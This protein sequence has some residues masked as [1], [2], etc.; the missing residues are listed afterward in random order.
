MRIITNSPYNAHAL[1]LF[2]KLNQLT[3]YDLNKLSVVTFMYR[4]H[5]QCLPDIFSNYFCTNSS[6]HSHFT[7]NSNKLHISYA[8]TDVMGFQIRICGPKLWNSVDPALIHNS[9][10]WR[11]FKKHYRKYLLSN[12]AYFF[13]F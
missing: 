12:Y 10:H 6:I 4:Y 9:R 11:H 8:R 13:S 5:N 3:I 1:P 7:R 2:S